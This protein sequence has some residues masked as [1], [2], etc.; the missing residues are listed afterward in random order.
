RRVER[1]QQQVVVD[2]VAAEEV[3]V[4]ESQF[5]VMQPFAIKTVQHGKGEDGVAAV[6]RGAV[7]LE[8]AR[9]LGMLHAEMLLERTD[10]V[11]RLAQEEELPEADQRDG[12]VQDQG[13][14]H[15]GLRRQADTPVASVMKKSV[16]HR[17]CRA[18]EGRNSNATRW[19]PAGTS[20]AR[21]AALALRI[22]TGA[23][24]I[25]AVQPG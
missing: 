15:D 13:A 20:T 21:K 4:P 6:G 11:E 5:A 1:V 2:R 17:P 19:L 10:V 16:P 9:G 22:G 24:S 14:L 25:D 23:P 7:R 8:P 12:A 3:R 18:Q